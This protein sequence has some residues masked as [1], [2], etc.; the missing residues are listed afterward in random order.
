MA[1]TKFDS[2][3]QLQ[4]PSIKRERDQTCVRTC[5]SQINRDEK[6]N[7]E[8]CANEQTPD[9]ET[10]ETAETNQARTD[11]IQVRQQNKTKQREASSPALTYTRQ[12]AKPNRG[13][14]TAKQIAQPSTR[15][16]RNK[17]LQQRKLGEIQCMIVDNS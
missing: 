13:N 6:M 8:S 7:I 1:S 17:Q 4:I 2:S 16:A 12:H 15:V 11:V 14:K 9:V 5:L 10:V 3:C